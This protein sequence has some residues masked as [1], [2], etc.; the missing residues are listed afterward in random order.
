MQVGVA[1][2][3]HMSHVHVQDKR[4]TTLPLMV[5]NPHAVLLVA[6]DPCRMS[7]A[8]PTSTSSSLVALAEVLASM[9][10][11]PLAVEH[12]DGHCLPMQ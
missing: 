2:A 10:P 3:H 9:N 7:T 5:P 11:C 1:L 6:V 12:G 8:V 4:H